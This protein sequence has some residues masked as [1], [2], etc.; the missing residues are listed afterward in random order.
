MVDKKDLERI[1][2]VKSMHEVEL[3]SKANVVGV[4]IGLRQAGGQSTGEAAIVVS[5]SAK[6]PE[7]QLAQRDMIPR[8]LDGVP[9]DVQ[10]VGELRAFGS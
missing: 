8:E 4:G 6:V 7:S 3:M 2:A 1:R 10:V 5:V 9:V